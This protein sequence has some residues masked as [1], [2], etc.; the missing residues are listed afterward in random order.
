MTLLQLFSSFYLLTASKKSPGN[1]PAIS[2]TPP[3]STSS[4]YCN[5]GHR[6]VGFSSINGDAALAPRNT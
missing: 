1:N 3:G 4:K 6:S 5:P 2:A